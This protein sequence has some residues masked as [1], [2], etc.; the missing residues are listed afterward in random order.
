MWEDSRAS[1]RRNS[2]EASKEDR[3]MTYVDTNVDLSGKGDTGT[4]SFASL[5]LRGRL[6]QVPYLNSSNLGRC[7]HFMLY[8]LA[9][10]GAKSKETERV[11]SIRVK[12]DFVAVP[13]ERHSSSSGGQESSEIEESD[14][15]S[16]GSSGPAGHIYLFE[17][18]RRL[19]VHDKPSSYSYSCNSIGLVIEELAEHRHQGDKERRFT[20]LGFCEWEDKLNYGEHDCFVGIEDTNIT[21]F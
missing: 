13:I 15:D 17:L 20:R 14:K 2:K 5:T 8:D 11:R 3:T 7:S 18:R 9:S 12:W 16:I 21:L 19:T 6:K 1:E 4:I 10:E